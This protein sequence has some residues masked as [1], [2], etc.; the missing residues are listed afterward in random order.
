MPEILDPASLSDADRAAVVAELESLADDEFV[1]AERYIDWQVRG[2]T[3][4]ADLA[5]ANIAQD[6]YGHAR[7][8]YDLLEDFGRTEAELIWERPR[9]EFRHTTMAELAYEVGDW[10]D[11]VLRGYLYD[12]FERLRLEALQETTYPRIADRV[13]KVVGEEHYHRDHA[14]N[15]LERLADGPASATESEAQRRL[16]AAL[17][18][19]YPHALTMFEPTEHESRIVASGVRPVS[20]AELREDWLAVTTPFLEGLGLSVPEPRLPESGVRGRDGTHSGDWDR[21]YDEFTYTYE[22]L[23]REPAKLMTDPDEVDV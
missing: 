6:E 12:H 18:R 9:E 15:W 11:C 21:L 22:M 5:V 17:E 7:L 20:L 1:V 14:E 4:E 13:G 23:G 10:A 8:W 2:P 19:L 16:Q 3:L